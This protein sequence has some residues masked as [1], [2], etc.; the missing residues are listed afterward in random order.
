MVIM[1]M[2]VYERTMFLQDVKSKLAKAETQIENGEV[3]DAEKSLAELRG[4]YGL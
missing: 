4:K 1:S 2:E 3:R